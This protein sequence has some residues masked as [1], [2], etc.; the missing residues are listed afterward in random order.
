[1]AL[2]DSQSEDTETEADTQAPH[3]DPLRTVALAAESR[4]LFD[5]LQVG[6]VVQGPSAEVLYCNRRARELLGVADESQILGRTSLDANN[7]AFR[8][9]GTPLLGSEHPAPQVI[10]TRRPVRDAVMRWHRPGGGGHVWLLVNADPEI[11]PD[12]RVDRVIVTLSDVTPL[13]TAAERL[14]ESEGRYRQLV[15]NAQDIIYR[16]DMWGFFT[17]VNPVATRVTGWAPDKII[18]KH[19][20]ELIR[21]DHRPHVE[22][23]LKAQ[24]RDRVSS[25]YDEFIAVTRG[26]DEIWIG[27]NVQLLTEGSKVLGFQAVAR[28]I[29]R[30]K[31][32]EEALERERRQ[33]RD[34][35][36]H[37]PVAMAILDGEGTLLAHSEQWLQLWRLPSSLLPVRRHADSLPAAFAEALV[38]S[39][40]G[41]VVSAEEQL[42]ERPDGSAVYVTWAVHPWRGPAGDMAGA[43]AVAQDIDVLVRARQAAQET[44]RVKSEFL[45]NV[46]HELRTPLSGVLGM[47]RLLLDTT[48][49]TTQKE[50]AEIIRRSGRELLGVV[51]AI[52]DFARAEAGRLELEDTEVE[53][54]RIVEEVCAS[55]AGEGRAKGLHVTSLIADEVPAVLRGDGPR[56]RQV[57]T[58]LLGNAIKFTPTG[59]VVARAG[60][61]RGSDD[62][63]TILRFEVADSG[64]GIDTATQARLFQ[65][66]V[67]ADGSATRHYGGA[68]LGLALCRRIVTAM[69]GQIGVRS[70]PGQGSTFWFTVRFSR[71]EAATR[72]KDAEARRGGRILV[73]EDN[74]VNQKV[75]VAM[76]ESLGYG[77]E[78]VGNGLEAVEACSRQNYEAILMDCQMPQMDGFKATAF[79][80]QREGLSH[81]T[82]IIALTASVTAEDRQRCLAAGMDD[83]LS[84]PVPREALASTLR[85]WIPTPGTPPPVETSATPSTLAASH[86]LRVLEAHAGPRALA[87]VIDVFLQTIPRRLD[88]LRQAHVRLDVDSVRAL[89]HSLKGASAQIGARGMA[90][91]CVQIEAVVRGGDVSGLGD[92]LTALEADYAVVSASLR[93]E[94]RRVSGQVA[95]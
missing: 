91:L 4:R 3:P 94:R 72:A 82:P 6:V 66:F 60:V 26:G 73:V 69:G 59:T 8:E 87:E 78:A 22:T 67:Q 90:D 76:I 25:T 80:R 53:P 68:G 36:V 52:L 35:V 10:A 23:H 83:Y 49:D 29:T 12:G 34:V 48:L 15:E 24:Y 86:P 85:K 89:A 17:Y 51:D 5:T 18:G 28:D 16:T 19:F 50:Y 21:E 32:A 95:N 37:A 62:A 7:V 39:R 46:S 30:R 47:V 2:G 61:V 92:I 31:R 56:L 88:D 54:G 70:E 43:V 93:E 75:A 77:A 13:H 33:L 9:D 74:T 64:I 81:R 41:P 1:M 11:G 65:P 27:Q 44:S 45:A 79:I 57:L 84:K 40:K 20:L 58:N 55:V 63:S 38:R 71:P 14:R 42:I